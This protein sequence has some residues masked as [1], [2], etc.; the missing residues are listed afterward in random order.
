M[1]PI[2]NG[3]AN[4][5]E[6]PE[7]FVNENTIS[8]NSSSIDI[9]QAEL[10]GGILAKTLYLSIDPHLRR[11][12]DKGDTSTGPG[13][14]LGK[15]IWGIGLATVLRSEKNGVRRGDVIYVPTYLELAL[16]FQ[17]YNIL[18]ADTPL[19]VIRPE[20]E[21]SLSAYLN[22]LGMPGQTAFYG[23]ESIGNPKA[24]ETIY[25]SAGAGAVGS[26]VAQLAKAKGLK[27]IASAG[28][29]EKVEEMKRMGVD[30]AFNYKLEDVTDVL[31]K[32]GPIDIY[33]DH[34][35]GPQLEAAI[36]ACN[37]YAR[38]IVCGALLAFNNAP[39]YHVKNLAEILY[40]RLR[41]QGFMYWEA[42]VEVE[43]HS[44]NPTKFINTLTPLVKSGQIRWTEQIFDGI[45]ST[46]RAIAVALTGAS[47]GK[48]I[49]K[50]ASL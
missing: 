40:K 19:R 22:V 23:L 7:R 44:G 49:V 21:V 24:G 48:V 47:T 50:I 27:V 35:G 13:Y 18:G 38:I 32:E 33:W 37:L 29:D 9:D 15:P 46:N 17:E 34:I 16:A 41:V 8:Y 6:A 39:P 42:E 31:A 4:F 36:G 43:G 20:P 25:V 10:N 5:N 14:E 28:S 30:V 2:T 45:E 3:S 11:W 1:A 12:M 26:L